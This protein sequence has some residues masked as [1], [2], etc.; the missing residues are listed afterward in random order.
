MGTYLEADSILHSYGNRSILT[1]VYLRCV[2]GDIIAIFG[3]NG[4]G[5]TTLFEI[6]TGIRKADR[7]FIRINDKIITKA[8]YKSGFI[9][10]LPQRSFLPKEL[11]VGRIIKLYDVNDSL[12]FNDDIVFKT[13]NQKV[14]DLSGGEIRY[15]EVKL[16]LNIDAPFVI[17]DEP[18][19]GLSPVMVEHILDEIKG[20]ARI[21]GIIL[22]DHK[23]KDVCK[24]ANR[25]MLLTDGYLKEI[26][27]ANE[28]IKSEYILS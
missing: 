8:T 10:F 24:I 3:R 14:R 2:P 26:N 20:S 23:Y 5:K 11:T 21:R 4:A 12:F 19:S 6:L 9:T 15:L 22:T 1:D 27:D 18:F 28:L 25:F 13:R 17:L 16:T 7:S